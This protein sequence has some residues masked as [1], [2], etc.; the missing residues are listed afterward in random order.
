MHIRHL[1]FGFAIAM[2]AVA[3][4]AYHSVSNVID[5]GIMAILRMPHPV[6]ANTSIALD[7]AI[8]Q[9]TGQGKSL[10]PFLAFL[11]RALTHDSYSGGH[12]DP[13]RMAGFAS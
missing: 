11:K 1:F 2:F 3:G 12:F 10:H 4:L 7:E 13:G 5:F 6:D 8:R 9:P